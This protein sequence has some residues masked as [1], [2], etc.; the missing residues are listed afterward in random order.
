MPLWAPQTPSDL[1]PAGEYVYPFNFTFPY[2]P[3]LPPSLKG[4]SSGWIKYIVESRIHRPGLKVCD[5]KTVILTFVPKLDVSS[6]EYDMP[7]TVS[8]SKVMKG[9][10]RA[11]TP[12]NA[13]VS[14]PRKACNPGDQFEVK[15]DIQNNSSKT[16]N[17]FIIV[18]R[19]H[20]TFLSDYNKSKRFRT[21]KDIDIETFPEP[22]PS[23]STVSK[24]VRITVPPAEQTITMESGRAI[25]RVYSIAAIIKTPAFH[26]NFPVCAPVVIGNVSCSTSSQ[27]SSSFASLSSYSSSAPSNPPLFNGIG[28]SGDVGDEPK[29]SAKE[30]NDDDGGAPVPDYL[31]MLYSQLDDLKTP[32]SNSSKSTT[33]TPFSPIGGSNT[34]VTSSFSSI[35]SESFPAGDDGYDDW[36]IVK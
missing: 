20:Y 16:L 7:V 34:Y 32:V 35:G 11:D 2:D 28:N 36:V 22:I 6:P 8:D 29:S 18:L 15:V 9:F 10:F 27:P 5:T 23:M 4:L 3:K 24:R 13:T 17:G 30:E 12:I 21:N 25:E 33:S 14:V 19:A 31:S 26:F 1:M